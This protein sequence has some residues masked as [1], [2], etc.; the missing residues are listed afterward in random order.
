RGSVAS[1]GDI[2]VNG[3]ANVHGDARCG[4]DNSVTVLGNAVITGWQAPLDDPP[5]SYPVQPANYTPPASN[6][7]GLIPAKDRPS[8]KY[9]LKSNDVTPRSITAG[10]NGV[11]SFS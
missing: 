2:T 7:N 1:N 8:G 10:T 6:D 11:Y 9:Q 3:T 5:L 4:V